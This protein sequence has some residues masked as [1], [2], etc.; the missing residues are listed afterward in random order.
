MIQYTV[1]MHTVLMFLCRWQNPIPHSYPHQHHCTTDR[2]LT[3]YILGQFGIMTLNSEGSGMC[4]RVQ[5]IHN[6]IHLCLPA[7]DWVKSFTPG[8]QTMHYA[9][10]VYTHCPG[11]QLIPSSWTS[12]DTH[13]S[14]WWFVTVVPSV[15]ML[16]ITPLVTAPTTDLMT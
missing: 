1:T 9:S 4:P 2:V 14:L 3:S 16:L 7:E 11:I 5:D 8:S 10:P 13:T 12:T 6:L 15:M